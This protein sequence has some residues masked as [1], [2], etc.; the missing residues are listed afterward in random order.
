[1]LK[2]HVLQA[3]RRSIAISL[4]TE[5]K[6]FRV[7]SILCAELHSKDPLVRHVHIKLDG[8]VTEDQVPH[9]DGPLTDLKH[10]SGGVIPSRGRAQKSQFTAFGLLG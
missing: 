4:W 9:I 8:A 7:L 3:I 6:G 2:R 1:M 10:S 5:V